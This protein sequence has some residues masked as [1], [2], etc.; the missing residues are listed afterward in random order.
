MRH[1][2]RQT[3]QQQE[4]IPSGA[5]VMVGVSGGADSI[6]L[7]YLLHYLQRE[8]ACSLVVAHLNHAIRGDEADGDELFVR[9]LCLRLNVPFFSARVDVPGRVQ[10]GPLS[11][12]MAARQARF[13]FFARVAERVGSRLLALAHHADDQ[14]ETVLLRL[15]RGAGPQGLAGLPYR[16]VLH[17]LTIIRPLRDVTRRQVVSF[18]DAHRLSWRE[19]LSNADVGYMRNRVRHEILP[20]LEQRMNPQV[21]SALGRMATI[22]RDENQWMDAQAANAL[23]ECRAT[24]P[25]ACLD[26]AKLMAVH[27]ALRR[28]LLLLW[29]Y[30]QGPES[31]TLS[32]AH[33]ELLDTL[34]DSTDGTQ[35]IHLGQGWGVIRR[36][37]LLFLEKMAHENPFFTPL[38][39]P[40]ET[41][42]PGI[43]ALRVKTAFRGT[44]VKDRGGKIGVYPR[45]VCLNEARRNRRPL[46]MRSWQAGDTFLPFGMKGTR[47]IQD[48]FVDAKVP[49]DERERIPLLVCEK[50]V[51]WVPGYQ[52]AR[53]WEVP[54]GN[55]PVLLVR[56][57]QR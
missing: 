51:V 37:N 16:N 35:R 30:E 55:G 11:L 33:L 46:Y 23:I 28:R 31:L 21:R 40:G 17:G 5:V 48:I 56:V 20:L 2:V 13:E 29:L 38:R 18:L 8:L 25:P 9:Q 47:K 12:E 42:L 43:V 45:F 34:T 14:V 49:R 7:L 1:I 50:H 32:M 4:L 53:G 24:E 10:T 57:E 54:D 3:I 44:L 19:D 22:M 6:A 41:L 39:I 15:C 36:Y 52:V 27:I 26:V